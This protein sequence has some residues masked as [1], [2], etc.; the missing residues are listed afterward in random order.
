MGKTADQNNGTGGYEWEYAKKVDTRTT[1]QKI[2]SFIYNP[3]TH[4]VLGRTAKSWGL[5]LL[6]LLTMQ[7]FYRQAILSNARK[8]NNKSWR[9]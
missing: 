1:S 3:G 2:L 4:A 6:I 7:K 8:G 9:R 5:L